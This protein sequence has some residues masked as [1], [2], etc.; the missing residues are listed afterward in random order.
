MTTVDLSKYGTYTITYACGHAVEQRVFPAH[1]AKDE[2]SSQRCLACDAKRRKDAAKITRKLTGEVADDAGVL[3]WRLAATVAAVRK[4]LEAAGLGDEVREYRRDDGDDEAKERRIHAR[5]LRVMQA[6]RVPCACGA[7]GSWDD[8]IS[9]SIGGKPALWAA[10]PRC[11][12]SAVGGG[13]TGDA[14][15][16]VRQAIAAAERCGADV[17]AWVDAA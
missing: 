1:R 15:A 17:D 10:C 4:A 13:I 9:G 11:Y 3:H 14:A 7:N 12:G 2:S 6:G 16:M 5:A 8:T